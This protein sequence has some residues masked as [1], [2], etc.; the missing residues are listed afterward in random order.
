MHIAISLGILSWTHYLFSYG[1]LTMASF[2][3]LGLYIFQTVYCWY[4]FDIFS[5]FATCC[6]SRCVVRCLLAHTLMQTHAPLKLIAWGLLVS[7]MVAWFLCLC[8][9]LPGWCGPWSLSS[10]WWTSFNLLLIVGR[11]SLVA[12]LYQTFLFQASLIFFECLPG[13]VLDLM[14]C[15]TLSMFIAL[16]SPGHC[17]FAPLIDSGLW[18]VFVS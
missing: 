16:S 9:W 3:N 11:P 4:L 1:A 8:S 14:G 10:L 7:L 2:S 17:S 18:L 6:Y 15:S 12:C 5:G 13:I